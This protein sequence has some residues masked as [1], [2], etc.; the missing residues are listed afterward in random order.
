L[1]WP[2][3]HCHSKSHI[4]KKPARQYIKE[5][6]QINS[7]KFKF[8]N[9]IIIRPMPPFI[10]GVSRCLATQNIIEISEFGF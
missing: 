1:N 9:E 4:R 3:I 2:K 6:A 8:A 5:R 7:S 10:L